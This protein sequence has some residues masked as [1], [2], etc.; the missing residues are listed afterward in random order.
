MDKQTLVRTGK[1]IFYLAVVIILA[2]G[3]ILKST[4]VS[5]ASE[6]TRILVIPFTI[7]AAGDLSH[8]QRGI[9]DMLTSRLEQNNQ[10]VVVTSDKKKD[11]LKQVAKSTKADYIVTG[12]VTIMGES[13]STDAKVVKD[14]AIDEPILS[15]SRTGHKQAD[16]IEHI[17]ALASAIG[18][19]FL[20]SN[21]NQL[22]QSDKITSTAAS[23]EDRRIGSALEPVPLP[24]IEPIKGQLTGIAAGDVDGDGLSDIITITENHLSV[25]QFNQ[26]KWIKLTE[27]SSRGNFVGVDIADVNGNGRHEIFVTRYSQPNS[28]VLSFVLEWDDKTLQPIATQMPWFFRAVDF[29]QR[30]RILVGQR[31]HKEKHFASTIHEMKYIDSAY[32]PGEPLALPQN[33]NI[34]GFAYGAVRSA[35]KPEVV[36]YNSDGYVQL[37][38]PSGKESFS[39]TELYGGGPN[40]LVFTNAAQ[41]DVQDYIYLSPRIHL[42]DMDGD[43]TLEILVLKNQSGFSGS[44][45]LSR[46]RFYAKGHLEWLEWRKN[47]ICS[48][49]RTIDMAKFIADSTLVDIDG[50]ED[51]E[52]VAA[53]VKKSGGVISKGSSY[54]TGFNITSGN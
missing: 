44:N 41:Y 11:D 16:V 23:S 18:T 27:Y 52:V 36:T 40:Y 33:L 34:F 42:Y 51:L 37:L 29:H 31:Q 28:K 1:I 22:K 50:D 20:G 19:R 4:P 38:S 9:T 35:N 13:I 10:A 24:G 6:T 15:F 49:M 46:Q 5:Y 21:P 30:G 12:S 25:Y 47:T 2:C 54:L 32:V 8:M 43:N 7:N 53:V 14:P 45:F 39:T 48:T 3:G 26:D 17:D